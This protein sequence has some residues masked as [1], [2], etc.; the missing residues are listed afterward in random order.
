MRGLFMLITDEE[1][2][3]RMKLYK[4][5]ASDRLIA[6]KLNNTGA[7]IKWR[8]RMMI[9]TWRRKNNLKANYYK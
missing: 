1:H 7:C 9:T 3:N 4:K 2:Q 6:E 5:G 8:T